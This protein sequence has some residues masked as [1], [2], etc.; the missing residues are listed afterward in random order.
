ME[1]LWDEI[2]RRRKSHYQGMGYRWSSELK[3]GPKSE[4]TRSR[5]PAGSA[6]G[7]P[8]DRISIPAGRTAVGRFSP[9]LR[10][11]SPKKNKSHFLQYEEGLVFRE[12][13]PESGTPTRTRDSRTKPGGEQA[14]IGKER[15]SSAVATKRKFGGF[16]SITDS[17][18]VK[19]ILK[20]V[21]VANSEERSTSRS[22]SRSVSPI[23]QGSERSSDQDTDRPIIPKLS[24]Q[25]ESGWKLFVERPSQQIP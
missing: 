7:A 13:S 17:S 11:G 16:P 25:P 18:L 12:L 22:R 24:V 3:L 2:F 8:K 5:Y 14:S 15:A 6:D 19:P 10:L 9:H 21:A 4:V 1:V 23:S 20:K